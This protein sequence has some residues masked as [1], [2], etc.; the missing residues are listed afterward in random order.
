MIKGVIIILLALIA[1]GL[2][3]GPGFRR[4]IAKLLGWSRLDR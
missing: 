2:V 1:L 4:F 3:S